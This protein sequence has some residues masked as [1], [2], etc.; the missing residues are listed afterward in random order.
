MLKTL[1]VQ[2]AIPDGYIAHY[3]QMRDHAMIYV[4]HPLGVDK[5]GIE[6]KNEGYLLREYFYDEDHDIVGS[7]LI[8][9]SASSTIILASLAGAI[10]KESA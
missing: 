3:C 4:R 5:Y 1:E 8:A 10:D 9:S 6:L 7:Q 2:S